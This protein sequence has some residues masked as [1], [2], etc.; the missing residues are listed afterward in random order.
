MALEIGRVC[1]KVAGREAGKYCVVL[2][3]L[4]DTFVLVTGPKELTGVKRRRCNVEHLE[5]T[6]HL[7]SIQAEANEKDVVDAYNKIGLMKKFELK[8]PSP[9]ILKEAEKKAVKVPVK[10]EAPKEEKKVKKEEKVEKKEEAKPEEKPKE[11]KKGITLKLKLPS[12]R[13]GKK[14]EK[15]VEKK[16]EVKKEK[17]P[18]KPKKKK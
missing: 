3:K 15:K 12:L 8:M 5:P 2:K 4:D 13:R 18:E 1:M 6:P 9:E 11:E 7:V 16:E 10:V 14:E 17:K